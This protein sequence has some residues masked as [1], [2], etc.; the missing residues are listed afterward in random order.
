MAMAILAGEQGMAMHAA[1]ARTVSVAT[2]GLSL[3]CACT[4]VG[5]SSQR[6]YGF[7]APTEADAVKVITAEPP[8]CEL[9]KTGD[10]QV[11]ETDESTA[12]A[13]AKR[14]AAEN[15]AEYLRIHA[16]TPNGPKYLT[17]H[18]SAYRCKK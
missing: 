3:L 13:E 9:V 4:A 16:I 15:G 2:L 17:M 18:A 8:D 5:S 14:L 6:S 7:Y 10:I 1:L 11:K 12:T